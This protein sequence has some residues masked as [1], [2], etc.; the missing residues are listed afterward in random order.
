LNL[1][2]REMPRKE[3]VVYR[4]VE[5][6]EAALE[7]YRNCVGELFTWSMFA[8]FTE[9]REEA[10]EY[11]RAWRGGISVIFEL[12]SSWCRRLRDG[13][14]LLHPFA[15][16]QVEAV[17]GNAVKLVEVDLVE[18]GLFDPLPGELPGVVPKEGR[19]TE[20]HK[21]AECG[22][23]R[24]I[25]R[26]ATRPEFINARNAGGWT[27]LAVAATLVQIEALK[28]LVSLGADMNVPDKN[29][30]TPLCNAAQKGRLEV[31]KALASLGANLSSATPSGATALFVAAER[32][33][34]EVVSALASFG[35]DVNSQNHDGATPAF[36]AAQNGDLEV[37]KA[38]GS[39]GADVNVAKKNGATPVIIAAQQGHLEVVKAL[40]SFGANVNTPADNGA[41][42]VAVAAYSGHLEV[43]K[44]LALLGANVNIPRNDGATPLFMAAAMGHDRVVDTLVS[45]GADV[46]R[47]RTNRKWSQ[48]CVDVFHVDSNEE[49]DW[50]PLM[51][52]AQTG[53]MEVVKVLLKAGA[54]VG[55]R[56]SDGRTALSLATAKGHA[57]VAALL[58]AR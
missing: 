29:G 36:I 45:L 7:G 41:T 1:E 14:F 35:A 50:T 55:L 47:R 26:F 53:H 27:P 22:D 32:G 57:D 40:A 28:A 44:A 25:A 3:R 20:L 19:V 48:W 54:S 34:W 30:V 46:N 9:E 38:L 10:E 39:L 52:A 42:P 13:P 2:F 56:L 11:G 18:P 24:A 21:A 49:G 58:S 43:V 8:S 23:V 6:S 12:R 16:L 31:V 15:V 5:L 33:H 37:L 4:G 17:V 51:I